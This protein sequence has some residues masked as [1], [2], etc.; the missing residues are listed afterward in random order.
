MPDS[1][2]PLEVQP[3][4]IIGLGNSLRGDDAAGLMAARRLA[5][6]LPR[7]VRVLELPGGGT[8]LLECWRDADFVVVVDA[9]QSGSAPGTVHRWD[10]HRENLPPG[11]PATSSHVLGLAE[12]LSLA[13]TLGRMPRGLIVFGIEGKTFELGDGLSP[14]VAVAVEEAADRIEDEIERARERTSHDA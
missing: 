8:D 2:L 11:F 9:V 10:A 13:R 5:P 7:D 14:Q 12:T 6:R 3:A 4:L 1:I